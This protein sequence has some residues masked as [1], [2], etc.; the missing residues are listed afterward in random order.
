MEARLVQQF[1]TS[2]CSCIDVD[3]YLNVSCHVK[4]FVKVKYALDSSSNE[5]NTCML[6][7]YHKMRIHAQLYV[8]L[9]I[10]CTVYFRLYCC[11]MYM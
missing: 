11:Y 1:T 4:L 9:I 3:I 8:V 2:T 6:Y 10:Q 7:H 5:V